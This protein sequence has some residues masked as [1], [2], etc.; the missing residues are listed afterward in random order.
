MTQI[1]ELPT[2]NG[3]FPVNF[4]SV[5]YAENSDRSPMD[6]VNDPPIPYPQFPIT[7][8]RVTKRRP[9]LMGKGR[10][11]L[12]NRTPN[13]LLLRRADPWQILG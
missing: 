13:T 10:Q 2:P 8:Q 3:L 5:A 7:F 9:K 1:I 4:P 12:L 11:L 6:F